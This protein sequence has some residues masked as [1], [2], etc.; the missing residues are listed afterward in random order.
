MRRKNEW[1]TFFDEHAKRYMNE[2]FTKNTAKEV[3]FIL[4]ELKLK[5]GSSI[6]DIGCGTGRH[7]LEL[8]NRGFKVTGV[9]ISL[10]MLAEAKKASTEANARIRWVHA[11]ATKFKSRM[12]FDA[13]I[14]L[15]EGG[16]GLLGSDDHHIKHD[17][18]ILC[19][20][21]ASLNIGCKMILTAPNGFEKIR[22]CTQEDVKQDKFN[23]LNMVE[24]FALESGTAGDKKSI[25]VRECGYIPSELTLLFNQ[26]GFKVDHFWGGTAG[27]W[28][29]QNIN[30]DEIEIMVVAR[31]QHNI[32]RKHERSCISRSTRHAH[33]LV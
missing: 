33:K 32:H 5:P 15:C 20:I 18:A 8:A 31:K 2:A 3:E 9:D 29:R 4:E 25:V 22:K 28:Q 24:T 10:G 30:F 13:A 21:N 7:S 6:L 14:C 16:F 27:N 17:L 12:K 19:N 11:D 1:E 23:P 26:A